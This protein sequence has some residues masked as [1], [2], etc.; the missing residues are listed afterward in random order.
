[1]LTLI[2]LGEMALDRGD[3][4]RA[5]ACLEECV[6]VTRER[7]NPRLVARPLLC[8]AEVVRAQGDYPRAE[9]LLQ[10]ALTLLRKWGHPFWY[11]AEMLSRQIAMVLCNLGYV[12][13]HQGD[14]GRARGFFKESLGE[15]SETQAEADIAV[16]LAGM[17]GVA[18]LEGQPER[19]ARLLGAAASPLESGD[20]RGH[21]NER[22][23]CARMVAAVR[24][25]LPEQEFAAAW[26]EGQALSLDQAV[27]DARAAEGF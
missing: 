5:R 19:A 21:R 27:A 15:L 14:A 10:E 1:M 18:Y 12:A 9:A 23:D 26:V 16:C 25:A 3:T 6:S 20:P 22:A 17:A 4:A 24:A 8:L 7:G 11:R 2:Y 13:Y